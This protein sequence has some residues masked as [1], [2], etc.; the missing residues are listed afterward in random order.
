MDG[1]PTAQWADTQF[2]WLRTIIPMTAVRQLKIRAGDKPDW[3]FCFWVYPKFR[4]T[5]K[6][7]REKKK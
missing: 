2:A 7:V 6:G 5:T 1:M 3:E 4:N